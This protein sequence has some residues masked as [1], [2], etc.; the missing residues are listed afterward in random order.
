MDKAEIYFA[1]GCFWGLEKY[2]QQVHG[3]LST[4]V[5]YANG[6]TEAPTYKDVCTDTTGFAETVHVVYDRTLAPLRFLLKLFFKA[7]DPTSLNRQGGDTG[8]QYRTGVF[9]VDAGDRPV[10]VESL[11]ELSHAYEHPLVV[12]CLPLSNYYPA[13]EYHQKYLDKHPGGYCH[14]DFSAFAFA[15]TAAPDLQ[16]AQDET[17][18]RKNR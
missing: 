4:D 2:F 8:T 3:V 11:N 10:I 18:Q 16:E 1:G 12:E 15:K 14:L 9:Y 17:N 6:L 13:E 7:I 5:G